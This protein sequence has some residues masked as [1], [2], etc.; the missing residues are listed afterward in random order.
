M[1]SQALLRNSYKQMVEDLISFTFTTTEDN[2][3]KNIEF[4][5]KIL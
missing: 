5:D 3:I 4:H 1:R 2:T